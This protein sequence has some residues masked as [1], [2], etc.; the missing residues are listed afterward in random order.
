VLER[1]ANPS[2]TVSLGREAVEDLGPRLRRSVAD[3]AHGALHFRR[4]LE[5]L[6]RLVQI[7]R[8]SDTVSLGAELLAKRHGLVPGWLA[9]T[10][11]GYPALIDGVLG[12]DV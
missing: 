10:D 9:E 12:D 7:N 6:V 1:L 11:P 4:Q 8:L 5:R 2:N 3:P